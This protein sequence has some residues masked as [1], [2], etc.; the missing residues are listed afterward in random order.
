M[1]KGARVRGGRN[2]SALLERRE[3]KRRAFILR[4]YKRLEVDWPTEEPTFEGAVSEVQG[5]PDSA[6][7]CPV[8][9]CGATGD[10]PCKTKK[11]APS[12]RRHK[13]RAK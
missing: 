13:D 1:S 9:Y 8:V 2:R 10:E 7:P 3:G 12:K 5:V 11:G 4:R 6:A